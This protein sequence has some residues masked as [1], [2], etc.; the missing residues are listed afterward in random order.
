MWS[1]DA[2]TV[3]IGRLPE[4]VRQT[5]SG[6]YIAAGRSVKGNAKLYQTV[7]R[8]FGAMMWSNRRRDTKARRGMFPAAFVRTV[9][10]LRRRRPAYAPL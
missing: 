8:T 7:A 5:K 3:A 6:R 10:L 9:F 2:G 4:R 1:A